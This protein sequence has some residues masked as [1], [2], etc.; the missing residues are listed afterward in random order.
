MAEVC[1]PAFI[2]HLHVY[3]SGGKLLFMGNEFGSTSEWNYKSELP[4]ELLQFDSHAGLKNCVKGLCHLLRAE[5]ALYEKQFEQG[6]SN[7]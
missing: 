3:A 5:P 1:Q 4:W 7:G 6:D 2:I